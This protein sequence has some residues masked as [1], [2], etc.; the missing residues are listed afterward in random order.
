MAAPA[1]DSS[2][3]GTIGRGQTSNLRA[4]TQVSTVTAGRTS[5][6]P[7]VVLLPGLGNLSYVEQWVARSSAWTK[8]T[9]LDL[10]GWRRGRASSCT[11]TIEG[12]AS[13]ATRWLEDNDKRDLIL[14]GHSSGAQSAISVALQVPERLT[15]LVL[16][17]PV[18]TPDARSVIRALRRLFPT[19]KYESRDE[20]PTLTSTVHAS[21]LRA[22]GRL[23][24]SSL[25]D[26]P[27]AYAV[28]VRVP[29]VVFTGERDGLADP[30]WSQFAGGSF[31][32]S[33]PYS[34]GSTQRLL[35]LSCGSRPDLA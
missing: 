14:L 4:V 11:P 23:V 6:L 32:R 26:Q 20:L 13:A 2:A 24:R 7:E 17:G 22:M 28:K 8:I 25:R 31:P 27:E 30:E 9:V 15:G 29:A 16:A 3:G 35:R 10:P 18:W 21:G 19:L 34:P 33:L 5:A 1:H 12:M